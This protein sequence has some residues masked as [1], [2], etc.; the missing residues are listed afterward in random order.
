MPDPSPPSQLSPRR[1]IPNALTILRTALAVV[2]VVLM[3][4]ADFRLG[5]PPRGLLWA[6]LVVFVVAAATD[7]LDGYLARRWEVV[8]VF[9]RIMDP[10]ADKVLVLGAFVLMAG[11]QFAV[12][13]GFPEPYPYTRSVQVTGIAPWMVVVILARDLL[14]TT[15][16]GMVEGRGLSF[17]ASPAG[18]LKMIVQSAGVPLILLALAVGEDASD[19]ADRW[20]IVATAWTITAV[21]ALSAI[22]YLIDAERKLRPRIDPAEEPEP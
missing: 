18:K 12:I 14:I 19:G 10:F 13:G 5:P 9:G 16:R 20:V 21:T 11:P 17:A 3:S 7:A 4:V 8:S 22:P 15:I 2:F 6:A 1:H